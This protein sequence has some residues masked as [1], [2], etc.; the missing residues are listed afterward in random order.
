MR[1]A[2]LSC[3]IAANEPKKAQLPYMEVALFL[4]QKGSIQEP[5]AARHQRRLSNRQT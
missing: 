3:Q 4:V 1:I 5:D 2:N